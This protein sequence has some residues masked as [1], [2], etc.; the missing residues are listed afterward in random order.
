MATNVF[1]VSSTQCWIYPP[2]S[3]TGYDG[4]Y[5]K[6]NHWYNGH[7]VLSRRGYRCYQGG[8]SLLDGNFNGNMMSFFF[9]R[10]SS[11]RNTLRQWISSIG[12]Y[13]KI[14]RITLRVYCGDAYYSSMKGQICVT[15]YWSP[16]GKW[17]SGGISECP[18][19]SYDAIG[20]RKITTAYF[21]EKAYT[22]VDLTP[23]ARDIADNESICLYAPGAYNRDNS[24][25]GWVAA[26]KYGG[27]SPTLTI[28]Y[29][30]NSAP[31]A[32]TV[33]INNHADTYGYINPYLD[34]NVV[35]NGDPD[36]NLSSSPYSFVLFNQNGGQIHNNDWVS[37]NHFSYDLSQYRG[38][39]VK[40][41]GQI[42]D[43]DGL[44]TNTDVNVYINSLPYFNAGSYISAPGGVVGTIFQDRIT[45]S[46]PRANDGQWQH[47]NNLRYSIYCQ[48]GDDRGPGAD[49]S[50]N[51]IASNL[52]STSHSF[53]AR[54]M[55]TTSG[56]T[57]NVAKGERVYFSVWV[58]DGLEWSANRITSAWLYR[59]KPPT[60]PSNVTPTSGHYESSVNVSWSASSGHNGATISRYLLRLLNKDNSVVREYSINGTSTTC[61][62]LHLIPRGQNFKFKV[63]AVDS[64]NN[65]SEPGYSG[66]LRRNSAPTAPSNFKANSDSKYFKNSIPLVWAASRDIDG[67]EV[68]YD[69]FY[70]VNGG[71]FTPLAKGVT[72]TFI[73]HDIRPFEAGTT[74][75][76]YI[77]AF[78]TFGVR[79]NKVYIQISPMVNIPPEAP[80]I[81]LPYN[82]RNMY[83]NTPRIV[84]K[85]KSSITKKRVKAIVRVNGVEYNSVTNSTMF[86]KQWY[87]D[88][89]VGMFLVP[90]DR[91]LNYS[92]TNSIEIKT[93]DNMDSSKPTSINI[94]VSALTVNKI[95]PDENR[96][97]LA[98][99]LNSIREMI[100]SNLFAY[101]KPEVKWYSG[102]DIGAPV[103]LKHFD[104]AYT[105]IYGLTNFIN[106]HT[107]AYHM[108]R[109]YDATKDK[110]NKEYVNTILDMISKS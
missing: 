69:I 85:V 65:E 41:R 44:H 39:T 51:C 11:T 19:D 62:D 1:H 102:V 93:D 48:K 23:W 98:N 38:Q 84:F 52:T 106:N 56:G 50:S 92:K 63:T 17:G 4:I 64:L 89:E 105:S 99:E 110:V 34:F 104:Q 2:Q 54:S 108:K 6:K 100:N 53:D 72:S 36:N 24:V 87:E 76:Y 74:F 37:N 82:N 33:R 58:T 77:E 55:S 109:I 8:N 40:I 15:P 13:Q 60:S 18:Y 46:W 101:G 16:E 90:N 70:N 88:R 80:D 75:N 12:G 22:D 73:N 94:P 97:I 14:T 81:L 32:P 31:Y 91:V 35:S 21:T 26:E 86:N 28:D 71:A 30:D 79:S 66:T 29:N 45:L 57:I 42:R 107:D 67:D 3:Y 20:I 25:W 95:Q 43:S 9:F 47:N 27:Q 96:F 78:D 61:N 103:L 68:K 49:N 59:E 10:D 5:K 7:S 83:C